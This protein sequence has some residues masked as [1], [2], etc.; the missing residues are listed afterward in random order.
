MITKRPILENHFSTIVL[1]F[2]ENLSKEEGDKGKEKKQEE[3][4]KEKAK[5]KKEE[6]IIRKEKKKM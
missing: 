4:E 2:R 1:K 6:K 5:T 3:K